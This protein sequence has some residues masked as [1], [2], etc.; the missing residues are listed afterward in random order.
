MADDS[1][2]VTLPRSQYDL[3]AR[4]ASDRSAEK[5][6]EI[7]RLREE[8]ESLNK[9]IQEYNE[10]NTI[11]I[12]TVSLHGILLSYENVSRD[13]LVTDLFDRW[14]KAEKERLEAQ[15]KVYKTEHA[16][17]GQRLRYLI[18]RKVPGSGDKE[19]S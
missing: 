13:E 17:F 7:T 8:N 5:R 2:M 3:L 18:T 4:R 12:K 15:H 19:D 14:T 9:R 6:V 1:G 11:C 16:S 10:K